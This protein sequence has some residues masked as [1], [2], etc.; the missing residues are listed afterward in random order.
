MT[1]DPSPSSAK[2]GA[3]APLGWA[4]FLAASWTWVI[5]MFLP[6]LLVRDYGV[7]GFVAFALPN[8]VGAAAMGWVVTSPA[9]SAAMVSTHRAACRAFSLVTIAFHAYV[10]VWLYPTL[11]PTGSPLGETPLLVVAIPPLTIIT[12]ALLFVRGVRHTAV[13]AA[14]LAMSLA[15]GAMLAAGGVADAWSAPE[16][17]TPLSPAPDLLW[18]APVMVFGF[19]LCPY[20]D[21]TFHRA[22]RNLDPRGA[23]IAFGLGF[24]VLFAAMI[25]LTLFYAP[26]LRA[27]LE[28]SAALPWAVAIALFAHIAMQSVFTVGV[29]TRAVASSAALRQSSP[30]AVPGAVLVGVAAALASHAAPAGLAGLS[31]GEVG[32][33]LFMSFY[34]LVFPAYAWLC[35]I[36]TRGGHAG[37]T[38]RKSL[39]LAMAI[40]VAAPMFYMGFV[41][42]REVFLAPGLLVVLMSRLALPRGRGERGGGPARAAQAPAAPSA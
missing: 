13:A 28:G 5:G 25:L 7:W 2:P 41:E 4:A 17:T 14:A 12:V 27:A 30:L 21:L 6:V 18:L 29:H 24:G 37:P 42:R 8:I 32:Y 40:G 35:M 22:R 20:L 9:E 23:R 38:R 19:A 3:L 36:P 39:V 31:A 15:L 26:V 16:P 33:R 10:L 11:V 1:T 34:G